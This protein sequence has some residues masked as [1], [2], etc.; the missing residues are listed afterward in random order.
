MDLFSKGQ[1]F[2]QPPEGKTNHLTAN[3]N[4]NYNQ[5]RNTPRLQ[6]VLSA[7]VNINFD[8]TNQSSVGG[9]YGQS[10]VENHYYR[11]D[12]KKIPGISLN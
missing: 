8:K 1:N 6:A 2:N 4:L 10:L 3:G 11:D 12:Q 9:I 7:Q 5:F